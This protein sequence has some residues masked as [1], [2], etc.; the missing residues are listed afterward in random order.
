M[1]RLSW[2]PHFLVVDVVHRLVEKSVGNP[3][4]NRDQ[5]FQ[6]A[7]EAVKSDSKLQKLMKKKDIK[8]SDVVAT[9]WII[10]KPKLW[11]WGKKIC[12]A[13]LGTEHL[14]QPFKVA[15]CRI[16]PVETTTRQ[17]RPYLL[18]AGVPSA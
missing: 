6:W 1:T 13:N 12:R 18:I 4:K 3:V 15:G 14:P 7:K 10:D 16:G 5:A 11:P 9:N 17:S 2:N 8:N